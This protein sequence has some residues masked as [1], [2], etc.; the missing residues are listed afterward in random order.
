MQARL[1]RAL[2][3]AR[4]EAHKVAE[5][6]A[7][8]ELLT[9]HAPD[10]LVQIDCNDTLVYASPAA[11][12]LGYEPADLVG[13]RRS[14]LIHPEDL[15]RLNRILV[16]TDGGERTAQ[17]E[18]QYRIRHAN[19][20]WVWVEGSLSLVRDDSGEMVEGF[21]IH[22]GGGLG[23]D[24]GFG[25]KLRGHKVTAAELPDYVERLARN[26]VAEKRDG[27]RFAQWVARADELALS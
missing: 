14:D 18:R 8:L 9:G 25:R 12:R 3:R 11:R 4:D 24:A 27:E 15:E 10:M 6:E 2:A 22:L 1:A 23:L 21:Q 7:Q 5:K 13:R 19:G 26:Y 17:A 16:A 20:E